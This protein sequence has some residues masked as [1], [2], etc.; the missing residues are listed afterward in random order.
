MESNDETL[1]A[2]ITDLER[3]ATNLWQ[4]WHDVQPSDTGD[5]YWQAR[6]M[7]LHMVAELRD[8]ACEIR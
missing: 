8:L 3:I 4:E 6:D 2:T 1:D 5:I 7:V